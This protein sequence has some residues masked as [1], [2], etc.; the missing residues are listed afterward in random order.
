M[1][2]WG[3]F[4]IILVTSDLGVVVSRFRFVNRGGVTQVMGDLGV[5]VNPDRSVN[6][7]WR[8]DDFPDDRLERGV[9]TGVFDQLGRRQIPQAT[10]DR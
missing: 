5:V 6:S 1:F 2:G 7:F 3:V 8:P 9:P 10:L 4:G